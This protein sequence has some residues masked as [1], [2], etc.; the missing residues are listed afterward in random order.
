MKAR[1]LMT[2]KVRTADLTTPVR[3]LVDLM[4]S[5]KVS[6]VPVVD[7]QRR[8]L[9]IVS[10]GDLL[11][12]A[13]IGTERRRSWWSR[14]INDPAD[15]ARD[16]VKSRGSKARDVMTRPVISVSATT[17]AARLRRAGEI[18]GAMPCEGWW[19]RPWLRILT[20]GR[21]GTYPATQ[22]CQPW[23]PCD[24]HIEAAVDLRPTVRTDP[25]FRFGFYAI[26]LPCTD[27]FFEASG[28]FARRATRSGVWEVTADGRNRRDG[29]CNNLRVSAARAAGRPCGLH[30]EV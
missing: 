1:D 15:D 5:Y 27:N 6:A 25:K 24:W 16:Y 4:V 28:S 30:R 12:R 26:S 10:E 14:L 13:E 21:A 9:G 19:N 29:T 7:A 23:L 8:V 2:R 11:R 18:I 22:H 20:G 3:K 17:S